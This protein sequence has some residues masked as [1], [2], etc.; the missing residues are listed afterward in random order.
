VLAEARGGVT[1]PEGDVAVLAGLLVDV[2][3]D[4]TSWRALGARGRTDVEARFSVDA[5]ADALAR[6]AARLAGGDAA[7]Q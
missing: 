3:A 5:S 1:Y 2:R 6:L 4:P 7:G